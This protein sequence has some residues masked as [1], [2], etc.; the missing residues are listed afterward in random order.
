MAIEEETDGVV[1]GGSMNVEVAEE[2]RIAFFKGDG[3][4]IEVLGRGCLGAKQEEGQ[5]EEEEEERDQLS[6]E[7]KTICMVIHVSCSSSPFFFL[8]FN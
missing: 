3:G 5:E 6:R 8:I 2:R 7:R 1:I 4:H